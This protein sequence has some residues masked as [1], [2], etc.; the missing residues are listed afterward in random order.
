[1]NDK[2]LCQNCENKIENIYEEF[3]DNVININEYINMNKKSLTLLYA[4]N[5]Y[6]YSIAIFKAWE[7]TEFLWKKNFFKFNT[8]SLNYQINKELNIKTN[9]IVYIFTNKHY[10][11][12]LDIYNITNGQKIN[13]KDIC[14]ECIETGFE[15]TNNYST[16]IKNELG[17]IMYNKIKENNIDIFS[18]GDKYISDVCQNFT[19]S[20]IDLTVPDRIN[21]L[22]IGDFANEMIC[23]DKNCEIE[24]NEISDFFGVCNCRINSD[25]NYLLS[26]DIN[27]L[28]LEEKNKKISYE[29]S[30]SV[31]KCIKAGFNKDIF[32][33]TGFYLFAIFIF[34]QILCFIFFVFLEKQNLL[35]NPQKTDI[36]NPP[37]KESEEDE[38]LF[39]E[40]FDII[41]SALNNI[42]SFECAEKKI[43]E[44]DEGDFI[45]EINYEEH[46]NSD[47]Y[48]KK[49]IM[50]YIKSESE[51]DN[52]LNTKTKRN[53]DKNKNIKIQNIDTN[54]ACVNNKNNK[55]NNNIYYPKDTFS[56]INI[57]YKDILSS[58]H[59]K[60]N[61]DF[62]YSNTDGNS[63][64]RQKN[65]LS[66]RNSIVSNEVLIHKRNKLNLKAK[67]NISN[68]SDDSSFKKAKMKD[69]LTFCGFYWYLIG[70]KQP[71]LN[72]T[73]QIKMFKITESFV[74]S[75]IKLIRFIFILG[76][77]FFSNCLFISQKYFSNKF[78]YFDKKYNLRFEDLGNDI[79]I[80]ERFSYSFR[81]TILYSVYSFIIC[82]VIQAVINFFYFN[83]RKRIN[84]IIENNKDIQEE[85]NDYLETVRKKYTF[86]FMI[87]ILLMI[88]FWFYIINFTGVYHGGDV[89]Y[90]AASIM[91]FI[92]L[93]IFPF[94]A[95]L[96]LAIFR[97]C[98]L[99]K[100]EKKIYKISQV[101]AY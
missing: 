34:L 19:I 65:R 6:N 52:S 39:I 12:N 101:F 85:L 20:K 58:K 94:F 25:Y 62:Y 17:I 66:F 7:C 54:E 64:L 16:N 93:Q 45:E 72:L 74:P 5:A 53:K 71:I 68:T 40:N 38:T 49:S 27:I 26:D 96:I 9:D 90:I 2:T 75:S 98:G 35:L 8:S 91:T 92:F 29:I 81:H 3:S 56:D 89:D 76:L 33:N 67:R 86:M 42:K 63:K 77:D 32:S 55:K 100:S 80:N 84:M 31:I 11:N 43:Q 37:K 99:K 69:N 22:Y 1:L 70:L 23:T 46:S 50:T 13:I 60:K 79:S 48:D 18:K 41:E 47:Y 21:Y 61:F 57:N 28:N 4:N 24:I 78:K 14:P 83:L 59:S 73:S 10:K 51:S 88:F 44:K 82:Y 15:I 87:N 36:V 97:H 30:L 95:C